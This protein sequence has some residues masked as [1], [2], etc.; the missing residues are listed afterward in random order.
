MGDEKMQWEQISKEYN[1][2]WVQ[3]IEYVWLEG[4]PFPQAGVVAVHAAERKDF[5]QKVRN[6]QPKQTDSAILYV[7]VPPKDPGVVYNN[8]HKVVS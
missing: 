4:T 2:Q 7:G 1:N 6:H 5:Y 8:F 3:L